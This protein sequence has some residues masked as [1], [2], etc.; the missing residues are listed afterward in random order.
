MTPI[1]LQFHHTTGGIFGGPT[2]GL[3]LF[4]GTP[5]TGLST[6]QGQGHCSM[7]ICYSGTECLKE[8]LS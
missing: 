3:S 7:G 2:I 1:G 4:L 8:V 5:K 6:V